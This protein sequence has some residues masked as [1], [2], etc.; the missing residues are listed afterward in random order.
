MTAPAVLVLIQQPTVHVPDP[1]VFITELVM[2]TM[3]FEA[4]PP[5]PFRLK[6]F[7]NFP[8]LTM[9]APP[10]WSPH[11]ACRALGGASV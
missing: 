8:P 5:V 4:L 3:L 6:A 2:M 11:L 9:L 7:P 10:V 1:S